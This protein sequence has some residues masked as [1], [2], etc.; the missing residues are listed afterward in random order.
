MTCENTTYNRPSNGHCCD[1]GSTEPARDHDVDEAEPGAERTLLPVMIDEALLRAGFAGLSDHKIA[2]AAD[3]GCVAHLREQFRRLR[4][5]RDQRA[6]WRDHYYAEA[7]ELRAALVQ[8]KALLAAESARADRYV[9][10]MGDVSAMAQQRAEEIS[11]LLAERDF[12]REGNRGLATK[13][14]QLDAEVQRLKIANEQLRAERD[15]AHKRIEDL[16]QLAGALKSANEK[17]EAENHRLHVC[18]DDLVIARRQRDDLAAQVREYSVA[19]AQ[20]RAERDLLRQRG[21][22]TVRALKTYVNAVEQL[23]AACAAKS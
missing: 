11:R 9:R 6:R 2:V 17:L 13:A 7:H 3:A 8:T 18:V 15:H 4:E 10:N 22:E 1:D 14:E 20:V 16:G 5:D 21:T 23:D 19:I 12:A